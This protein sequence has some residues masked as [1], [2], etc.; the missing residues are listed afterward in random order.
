MTSKYIPP[1]KRRKKIYKSNNINKLVVNPKRK[2]MLLEPIKVPEAVTPS[3][4]LS[5]RDWDPKISNKYT[6]EEWELSLA[7]TIKLQKRREMENKKQVWIEKYYDI[8]VHMYEECVNPKLNIKLEEFIS[9]AYSCT[10]NVYKSY[11]KDNKCLMK[12][13]WT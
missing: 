2:S 7:K 6:P 11:R 8:L 5:P 9:L 3:V 13:D 1:H 4:V 10:N 12:Q